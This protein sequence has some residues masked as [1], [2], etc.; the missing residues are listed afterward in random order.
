MTGKTVVI[1][2]GS[3]GIGRETACALAWAGAQVVITSRH[4]ERGNKAAA[5]LR[6]RT[7]NPGVHAVQMDLADLT[8]VREGA[9]E[10]LARFERID[11]LINN[12]GVLLGTH[13][14][15]ADGIEAT[16]A[17]NHLGPFALTHLLLDRI[18]QSA[19]AR[20]INVASRAHRAAPRGLDFDELASAKSYEGRRAYA[21]S[22]LANILFTRALSQRLAGSGVTANCLHPGA[23]AT[24]IGADDARPW[25]SIG[26]ALTR[27]LKLS[28]WQGARTPAYLATSPRVAKVSGRY[29]AHCR[30][31]RPSGAAQD[32][33]AAQHLWLVSENLVRRLTVAAR[34]DRAQPALALAAT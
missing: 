16:F 30:P 18:V 10:I 33:A 34:A 27:P 6:S 15:S 3:S 32:D 9:A 2:G 11:V 19:P 5:T 17:T 14:M 26:R 29:F 20:I 7:G 4:I 22:K 13:R 23:V 8:S 25:R 12:A 21:Q 28:A 24:G 1:T 31:V